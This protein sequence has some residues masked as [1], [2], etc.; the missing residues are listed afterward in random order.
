MKNFVLLL[1]KIF[2][3]VILKNQTTQLFN[4]QK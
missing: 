4:Q 1:A 3:I 2:E